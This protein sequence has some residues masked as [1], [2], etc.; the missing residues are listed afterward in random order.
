MIA[1]FKPL[2]L[3]LP[4]FGFIA[5]RIAVAAQSMALLMLFPVVCLMMA[6]AGMIYRRTW[7]SYVS[8]TVAICLSL[9]LFSYFYSH[10]PW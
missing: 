2:L 8:G 9:Y 10:K 1:R 3:M 7:V 4:L 6:I 5:Y